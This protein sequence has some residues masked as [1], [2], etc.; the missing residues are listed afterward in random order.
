MTAQRDR[1]IKMEKG[2]R[3][4]DTETDADRQKEEGWRKR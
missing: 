4:R 3:D 2:G 1:D